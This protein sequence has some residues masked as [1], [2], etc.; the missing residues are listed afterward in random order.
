MYTIQSVISASGDC[1]KELN[2]E[3]NFRKMVALS[4][5]HG[6]TVSFLLFAGRPLVPGKEEK[7]RDI[8]PFLVLQNK[9]QLGLLDGGKDTLEFQGHVF[10]QDQR[11]YTIDG[12]ISRTQV[13]FS[14]LS[15]AVPKEYKPLVRARVGL[16]HSHSQQF[17]LYPDSTWFCGSYGGR[18]Y[19]G[20][21]KQ[22]ASL[23]EEAFVL[24]PMVSLFGHKK[25]EFSRSILERLVKKELGN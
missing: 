25:I 4:Y 8:R 11:I 17:D 21:V 15:A 10:D 3:L 24:S 20:Q 1:L 19:A 5:Q 22:G 12:M 16:V 6:V 23:K 9:E 18:R 7:D 14:M 2:R 13:N